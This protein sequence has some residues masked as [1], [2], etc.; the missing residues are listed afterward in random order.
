MYE[1]KNCKS[2][3]SLPVIEFA[4]SGDINEVVTYC[5]NCMS[6]KIER[7]EAAY[8]ACCLKVKVPRGQKYCDKYCEKIGE[9]LEAR[10]RARRKKVAEFEVSKSVREVEEYNR[11]NG[12][13]Y[14]YGQYFA[15]K[16]MGAL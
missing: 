5:P 3:F 12:T 1:C 10:L 13:K 4:K 7:V 14:S 2:E 6:V 9:E 8:C 16:G 11:Q 15:L